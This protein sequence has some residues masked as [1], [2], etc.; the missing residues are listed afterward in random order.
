MAISPMGYRLRTDAALLDTVARVPEDF[1]KLY[2][3]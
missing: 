2:T 3:S 1:I